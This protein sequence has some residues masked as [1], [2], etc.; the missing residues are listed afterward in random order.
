MYTSYIHGRCPE[1]LSTFPKW[2]KPPL[3]TPS[4]AK[5]KRKML[6]DS[7]EGGAGKAVTRGYQAKYNKQGYYCYVDLSDV[8]STDKSYWRFRVILFPV[9]RG[10]HP[11]KS[12][13]PYKPKCFLKREPSTVFR[14]HLLFF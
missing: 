2:P 8:L 1:K 3:Q 10:R 5:D 12:S 7:E 4:L 13:F 14:A 11:F 6:A 9:Q